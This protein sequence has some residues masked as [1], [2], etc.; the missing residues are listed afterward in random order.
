M[1]VSRFFAT[2]VVS[3]ALLHACHLDD[4]D[5]PDAELGAQTQ[6]VSVPP[7][8][9]NVVADARVESGAPTSNRGASPYLRAETT[10]TTGE[11][12]SYIKFDVSGLSGT[13]QSARLRVYV[14]DGTDNGPKV[15][16][17]TSNTWDEATIT[18]NN[19]PGIGTL[20]GDDLLKVPSGGYVE[21]DVTSLV[22]GNGLVTFV[23]VADSADR[24]NGRSKED[25]SPPQ[26][27][28]HTA[29]NKLTFGVDADARVNSEFPTVEYGTV[30]YL[31]VRPL[32]TAQGFPDVRTYLRFTVT[33]V[34]A[35][36]TN[37]RVRLYNYE[38]ASNGPRIY[39]VSSNTWGEATINWSN[40]PSRGSIAL[41]DQGPVPSGT[42]YEWDVSDVISGNGTYSFVLEGDTTSHSMRSWAKEH[43]TLTPQLVVLT[44]GTAPPPVPPASGARWPI[45]NSTAPDADKLQDAYGPRLNNGVHDFHAGIDIPATTGTNVHAVLGGT[46]H[47]VVSEWNEPCCGGG[48]KVVI[49]HGGSPAQ[50][51]TYL[52]LDSTAVV[53]GATVTAGTVVGTVGETGAQYPHLHFT[54][55]VGGSG[56]SFSRNPLEL[57]PHT[58]PPAPG[59]TFSGNTVAMNLP[60]QKMKVKAITIEGAS[61]GQTRT[62]DYYTIVARGNPDRDL[63][64][65]GNGMHMA[66]TEP[67]RTAEPWNFVL[68]VQPDPAVPATVF[69]PTKITIDTFDG[70]R[71]EFSKP[72][73]TSLSSV[74]TRQQFETMFPSSGIW[75]YDSFLAAAASDTRFAAFGTTGD[76][77][78]KKREVAAFLANA[79]HETSRLTNLEEDYM[80][81]YCDESKSYGC[82]AGTFEYHGRG[83]LQLSWNY[84]YYAAGQYLGMGNDLLNNPDP[85]WQTPSL[86]WRTS[87][88][89]WMENP[90][91]S[92]GTGHVKDAHDAMTDGLG[93]T[94]M[95][96]INAINGSLEC[97]HDNSGLTPEQTEQRQSRIDLY[98]DFTVILG[99]T[100]ETLDHTR[101]PL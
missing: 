48:K 85:V 10:G 27:V 7:L 49:N 79:A 42:Y 94:F 46:V 100:A 28:I 67:D 35:S 19:K 52:H 66:V 101:C 43:A 60:V 31:W 26:L 51:T 97:D 36:V 63:Q 54:Y 65:Q 30:D 29:P 24:M 33:G 75:D 9:F 40:K 3:V 14:S 47:S 68:T 93:W 89:F 50:Y 18:W 78:M 59:V 96:T 80:G 11:V 44:G 12:Q 62:V 37:A 64:V 73:S 1:S 98:E 83:P 23:F 57:L 88:W 15:Y 70:G 76:T 45:S 77:T 6:A 91:A 90:G 71:W 74:I 20:A 17:A 38:W 39:H 41:D 25:P 53:Q 2:C 4:A 84:N 8:T 5:T 69:A 58:A 22:S 92:Y 61:S 81:D 55:S 34:S 16:K 86:G 95:Q 82:P 32:D 72:G 21:W 99:T 13:V 56:E 87:L